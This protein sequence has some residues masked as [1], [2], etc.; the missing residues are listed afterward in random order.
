MNEQFFRSLNGYK[1]KDEYAI[2]TYDSVALMKAD[3][4]LKEGMYVK[5]KGYTTPNDGGNG[6]Y[7]IVNDNSLES[8]NGSIHELINGLFAKLV[9]E[10]NVTPEQ[11]GCYGDD[12]HDDTIAFQNM[13]NK[14]L[15]IKL[16]ENK[17]YKI[18]STLTFRN[19]TKIVGTG[20]SSQ[21]ISYINNETPIFYNNDNVSHFIFQDFYINSKNNSCY[22]FTITN[23]YDNCIFKNIYFDNFKLSC[24]KIGTND[25]ISQTLLIDNCMVY[26]SNEALNTPIFDLTKCY[27][28]NILNNKL[29]N[30][31]NNSAPCLLLTNIYDNNIQGNSFTYS[32]DCAIKITGSNCR[33]NRIISNTYELIDSDYSI[34]L[35]GSKNDA[36]QHTMILESYTYYSA[37]NKIYCQNESNGFFVGLESTGGRRNMIFNVNDKNV[38]SAYG[39]NIVTTDDGAFTSNQF[40]IMDYDNIKRYNIK[41]NASSSDDYGLDLFDRKTSKKI[42]LNFRNN[43]VSSN[44]NGF[45]IKMISPDGNT[46]KY[47]G[48]DNNGDLTLFNSYYS[49]SQ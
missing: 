48:I 19:N 41:S 37:P 9:I 43:F 23:P 4:K 35:I 15:Y 22:G 30:R 1:V 46:T 47:L 3:T 34:K 31:Q 45:R 26:M 44:S 16:N 28:S 38:Q 6:E 2:H 18:T 7:I 21:I 25:R 24:L 39:N 32:T 11:F 10:N 12:E 13:L 8:D 49:D 29:L 33:H 20:Q 40:G 42:T 17:K 14:F 27:E 36:I 5:T